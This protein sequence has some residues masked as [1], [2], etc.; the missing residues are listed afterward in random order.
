MAKFEIKVKDLMHYVEI[1]LTNESVRTE[2][3]VGCYWR[4]DITMKNQMPTVGNM[5]KSAMTGNKIFRPVYTGTGTLMLRP[6]FHEFVDIHLN[7]SKV[8]FERG[9]YWASDMNVEIG[10]FTN[11]LSAGMMSGEGMMQTAA[12]GTGTVI[13][14]APGPIEVI[15]LKN[16]RIALDSAYAVARS[17]GLKYTVQKS[18]RG[19]FSTVSSGEGL[20]QV[21]EGTGTVYI[22]AIPNH[23][24][25]LQELIVDSLA[26]VVAAKIK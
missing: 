11:T 1:T 12:E 8:V 19:I 2:A 3:G 13:A 15:D 14:C 21:L 24:I 20:I 9:A 22:S 6:R 25:A 26:G 23:S 4:G 5:L 17:A 18:S 16:E 10:V 7:N